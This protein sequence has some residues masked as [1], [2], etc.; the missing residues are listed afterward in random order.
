MAGDLLHRRLS[1]RLA[2]ECVDHWRHAFAADPTGGGR[3]TTRGMLTHAS[4][5]RQ[6]TAPPLDL[7]GSREAGSG[8]IQTDGAPSGWSSRNPT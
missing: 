2:E 1:L 6:A 7:H 3:L 4:V 8:S 5:D